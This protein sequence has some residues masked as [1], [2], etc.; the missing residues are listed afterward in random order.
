MANEAETFRR[1]LAED[2]RVRARHDPDLLGFAEGL[3][4]FTCPPFEPAA[5]NVAETARSHL[6]SL[7]AGLKCATPLATA[8]R[9]FSDGSDWVRLLE[10]APVDPLL[11][12]GMTVARPSYPED[13]PAVFGLFLIGPGVHYPLHTHA[14]CEVYYVVSGEISI[15]HGRDGDAVLHRGGDTSVTPEHRV[16]A[17]T[18]GGQPCLIVYTWT[19]DLNGRAWWW[20]EDPAGTWRRRLWERRDGRAWAPYDEQ[21]ISA[22]VLKEAGET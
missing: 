16:H 13:P 4:Q 20:E 15:Q 8:I 19:G 7:L 11:E 5:G 9:A 3:E 18:T 22:D 10:G 14:A 1:A 2:L 21:A 6:P 17:L 12:G